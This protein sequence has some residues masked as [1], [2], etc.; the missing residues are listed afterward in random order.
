MTRQL[1]ASAAAVALLIAG[2]TTLASAQ[3]AGTGNPPAPAGQTPG[4]GTNAPATGQKLPEV[5]VI[6]QQQKAKAK[7]VKQA[8]KPKK[9]PFGRCHR[10]ST[11]ISAA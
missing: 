2:G 4:A 3:D 6:Q 7:P 8:S 1:L 11:A 10:R 5:Q 9:N